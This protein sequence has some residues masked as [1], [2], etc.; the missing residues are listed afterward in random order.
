MATSNNNNS[1]RMRSNSITSP[2]PNKGR[3]RRNNN[4]R[5]SLDNYINNPMLSDTM[6][7]QLSISTRSLD[8]Q[9]S[10]SWPPPSSS[11]NWP[12]ARSS[13]TVVSAPPPAA[14]CAAAMTSTPNSFDA[15]SCQKSIVSTVCNSISSSS[16]H[17]APTNPYHDTTNDCKKSSSSSSSAYRD[18]DAQI[19]I[20][21]RTELAILILLGVIVASYHGG[22]HHRIRRR[23]GRRLNNSNISSEGGSSSLSKIGTIVE[24]YDPL[25]SNSYFAIP[26]IITDE[27]ISTNNN[28]PSEILYSVQ[29]VITSSTLHSIH[30]KF[31]HPY[32]PYVDGTMAS[33][34]I[35]SGM[36]RKS[37]TSTTH[38][39]PCAIISHSV[40]EGTTVIIYNVSY[41]N[42][43]D[44]LVNDNLPF[45]RV[46]R[47]RDPIIALKKKKET[48]TKVVSRSDGMG[49]KE[50][51]A[52]INEEEED[53][54]GDDEDEGGDDADFW[55]GLKESVA[56][57]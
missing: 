49:T 9:S 41:L 7:A 11:T 46:Q 21:R 35:N 18:R 54:E 5:A 3:P 17:S 55:E 44:D 10:A 20:I 19:K 16:A 53:D 34:N 4:R 13:R 8:A 51:S 40:R 37:S 43:K 36:L 47:R 39:V 15:P 52:M 31:I 12:H 25:D 48:T 2:W 50:E 24:L 1:A 33:C 23:R 22:L 38:M 26:A 27:F 45:S 28:N 42:D 57:E 29:N 30:S 32:I 6:S 56:G 14:T